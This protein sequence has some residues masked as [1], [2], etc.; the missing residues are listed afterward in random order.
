M[1]KVI[2]SNHLHRAHAHRLVDAAP[3]RSILTIAPA[4]RTISQNA[5]FWAILSE[6]SAAK[7]GGRVYS[8]EIWK[9]L[10]MSAFGHELRTIEGLNGEPFPLG[11]SSSNLS[12]PQMVELQ[13][14]MEAWSA[15]NGVRLSHWKNEDGSH[16]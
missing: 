2:L 15:Q 7:P 14:F 3:D 6:I 8:P 12:V 10:F 4:K 11:F 9:A 16:D 1:H 13:D 5:R